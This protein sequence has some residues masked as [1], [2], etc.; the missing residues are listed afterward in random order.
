[1]ESLETTIA[2]ASRRHIAV[3]AAVAVGLGLTLADFLIGRCIV[4]FGTRW[5]S[6][7]EVSH[8]LA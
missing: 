5:P 4:D 6:C 7:F 8:V 1:M 3:G 2:T